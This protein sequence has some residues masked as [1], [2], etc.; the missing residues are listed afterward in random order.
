MTSYYKE[1]EEVRAL[2]FELLAILEMQNERN[3][4]RGI[5]AVTQEL[6][7]LEGRSTTSGFENARSIYKTMTA[8]GR[9]FAEYF[10]WSDNEDERI[11]VNKRLD[12]L[13]TKIWKLFNP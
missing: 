9:G 10:I 4:S 7:D 13:R 12:D 2:L 11:Q 8:G 6:D 3:W 1:A 5:K